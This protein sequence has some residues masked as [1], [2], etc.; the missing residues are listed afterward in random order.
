[1]APNRQQVLSVTRSISSNVDFWVDLLSSIKNA[2]G[3]LVGIR[4]P[5]FQTYKDNLLYRQ[6]NPPN[7]AILQGA[8]PVYCLSV[9]LWFTEVLKALREI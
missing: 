1:M 4:I 8:Q 7:N 5:N 3:S 2:L 6:N 9:K